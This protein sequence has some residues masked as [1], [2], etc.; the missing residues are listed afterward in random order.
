MPSIFVIMVAAMTGIDMTSIREVLGRGRMLAGIC[1]WQLAAIPPLTAVAC[2]LVPVSVEVRTAM[3]ASACAGPLFSSPAFARMF[4]LD[5][6]LMTAI[7]VLTT[8]L[9]PISLLGYG[10][11][12][13]DVQ[14]QLDLSAFAWRL[15][16]FIILPFALARLIRHALGP[17]GLLRAT[18]LMAWVVLSGLAVFALSVM[19][20]VAARFV[21]SPGLLASFLVAAFAFNVASQVTTAAAFWWAG[22]SVA[23]TA[24]L[25]SAYRNMALVLA[26]SGGILGKDFQI[27][28]GVAQIPMYVLPLVLTPLYRRLLR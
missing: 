10:H 14:L 13:L 23:W 4:G 17:D 19:D 12:L 11:L 18:P 9:M 3:I 6:T 22:P 2:T 15:F 16:L 7:V 21:E 25:A 5:D 28:V 20:G 27:Y 26:L 24:A 8:L 1:V